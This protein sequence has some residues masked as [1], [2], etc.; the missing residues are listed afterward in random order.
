MSSPLCLRVFLQYMNENLIKR[1]EGH[2]ILSTYIISKLVKK[3][4]ELLNLQFLKI[5]IKYTFIKE[6][7]KGINHIV[8]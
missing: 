7:Y 5:Q 4:L 2:T 8:Y 6:N 3:F 1:H